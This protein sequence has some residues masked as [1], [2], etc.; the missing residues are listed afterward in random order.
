VLVE[1]F[2]AVIQAKG[3]LYRHGEDADFDSE[4]RRRK[5][6]VPPAVSPARVGG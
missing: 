4:L 5:G 3:V 1:A 6:F 2:L